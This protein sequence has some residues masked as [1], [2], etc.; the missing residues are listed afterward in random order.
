MKAI[1]IGSNGYLGKH[2]SAF[3]IEKGWFIY[4]FDMSTSSLIPISKYQTIDISK[5]NQLNKV[6]LTSIDYLFYFSGLTGTLNSFDKYESY[7]DINEKGLLHLLDKIRFSKSK[8]R[9]IFPS[10]RLIYKGVKNTELGESAEK[11]FKTIYALNKWFGEQA[12][13]HYNNYFNLN[14]NIFRICIPYGNLFT[15]AYSY[16]TVGFFLGK[17]LSNENI[18]LYGT[19]E[20]KRTFTHV[21]D[22]CLQ[23]YNSIQN[24]ESINRIFN[25]AGESF[26]LFEVAMKIAKKYDVKVLHQKWPE[27]DRKLESGDTIFN[28]EQIKKLTVEPLKNTFDDWLLTL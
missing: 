24:P 10:S 28:A 19:G 23:I 5:K 22:I 16:G 2:L 6:D 3:L 1:V 20:Q 14:Y 27:L 12:I 17:A 9:I 8:L 21:E 13:Q 18:V 4:G 25:I 15:K 7:I 11:E 26:S